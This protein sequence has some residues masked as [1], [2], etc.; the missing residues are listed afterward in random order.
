MDDAPSL[1]TEEQKQR[2]KWD[3]V[4]ADLE[5]RQEQLRLARKDIDYRDDQVRQTRQD[6]QW[7]PWQVAFSAMTAGAALFAAGAAFI[8]L[9]GG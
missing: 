9:I 6:M 2:A 8:K 3:L 4:L 7:K 1:P 5:Y